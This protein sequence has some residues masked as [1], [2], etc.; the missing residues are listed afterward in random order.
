MSTVGDTYTSFHY[1]APVRRTIPV[2]VIKQWRTKIITIMMEEMWGM[3]TICFLG[4]LFKEFI[5][6][7]N[8][9][10]ELLYFLSFTEASL[11]AQLWRKHC[12]KV[13][14]KILSRNNTL[15]MMSTT[16]I[17]EETSSTSMPFFSFFLL[18]N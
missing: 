11:P 10:K 8:R 1:R 7:K 5:S 13:S 6:R 15:I 18:V 4:L 17:T 14:S 12:S 9:V 16:I 3:F 2:S